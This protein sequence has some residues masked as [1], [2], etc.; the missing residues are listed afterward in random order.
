MINCRSFEWERIQVEGNSCEYKHTLDGHSMCQ[1]GE[2]IY[3]F[4]G[5][6]DNI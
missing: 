3:I 4:G 2:Y 1:V 6:Y 5:Y